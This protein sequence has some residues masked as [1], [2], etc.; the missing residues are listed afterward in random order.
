MGQDISNNG[1]GRNI[2]LNSFVDRFLF[3]YFQYLIIN[4]LVNVFQYKLLHRDLFISLSVLTFFSWVNTKIDVYLFLI[5]L[6]L[7]F[8]MITILECFI[9]NKYNF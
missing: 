1:S 9:K 6:I 2:L 8:C 3:L 4:M 5:F 7:N